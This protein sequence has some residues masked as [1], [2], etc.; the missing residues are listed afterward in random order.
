MYP[1]RRIGARMSMPIK[2]FIPLRMPLSFEAAEQ[3]QSLLVLP[4]ILAGLLACSRLPWLQSASQAVIGFFQ[5]SNIFWMLLF[6]LAV[7][8]TYFL[9]DVQLTQQVD[10]EQLKRQGAVIPGIHPGAATQAYL[11]KIMQRITLPAALFLGI[12]LVF[13]WLISLTT[14]LQIPLIAGSTIFFLCVVVRDISYL[15]EAESKLMGYDETRLI[16]K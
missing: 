4:G 9:A 1:G 15:F 16:K 11:S 2:G 14:G 6:L 7:G 13:P 5:A 12:M 3:A 8:F 10:A